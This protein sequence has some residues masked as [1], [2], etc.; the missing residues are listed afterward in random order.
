MDSHQSG[1]PRGTSEK[2]SRH[3]ATADHG[4]R[5][6]PLAYH[7]G[8]GVFAID[9]HAALPQLLRAV[10]VW[11]DDRHLETEYLSL[12]SEQAKLGF[13]NAGRINTGDRRR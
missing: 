8:D 6:A 4:P 12:P 9:L 7:R 5:G 3:S 1:G 11:Q 13:Q 2:H 10:D